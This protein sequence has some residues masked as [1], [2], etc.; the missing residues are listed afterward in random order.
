MALVFLLILI[1]AVSVGLG[2]Y[3]AGKPDWSVEAF[4]EVVE[5]LFAGEIL[6]WAGKG[7]GVMK[8]GGEGRVGFVDLGY[9]VGVEGAAVFCGSFWDTVVRKDGYWEVSAGIPLKATARGCLEASLCSEVALD[10]F[11]ASI[12]AF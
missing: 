1:F 9:G 8:G 10:A 6:I 3:E 11:P 7:I 2:D 4:D 12:L 5:V